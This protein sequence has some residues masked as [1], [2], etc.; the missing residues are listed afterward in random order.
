MLLVS[1]RQERIKPVDIQTLVGFQLCVLVKHIS[2][3]APWVAFPDGIYPA[4]VRL[5]EL[6]CGEASIPMSASCKP[7][8]K[9]HIT[10]VHI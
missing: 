6:M 4:H 8:D 1:R 10:A 7:G 2:H 3:R 5:G 9:H